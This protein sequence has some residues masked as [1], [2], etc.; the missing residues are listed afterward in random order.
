[1]P[2]DNACIYW[3]CGATL[4][5]LQILIHPKTQTGYFHFNVKIGKYRMQTSV[6]SANSHS[7]VLIPDDNTD[8]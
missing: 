3:C 2:L 4:Y 8:R 6:S 7:L 1:M 5:T